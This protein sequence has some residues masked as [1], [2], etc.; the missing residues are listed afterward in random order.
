GAT[1]LAEPLQLKAYNIS[2]GQTDD[3]TVTTVA[4]L[5][6]GLPIGYGQY[7]NLE[8]GISFTDNLQGTLDGTAFTPISTTAEENYVYIVGL[9]ASIPDSSPTPGSI[10]TTGDHRGFMKVRVLS[11][12]SGY[13]L[14]YA[15]LD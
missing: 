1:V 3:V 13:T 6:V 15:E 7:G 8:E 10:E 12:A 11:S 14:Q 2:T 9:G 4:D 5:L